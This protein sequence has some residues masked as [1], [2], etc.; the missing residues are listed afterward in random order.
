MGY[1]EDKWKANALESLTNLKR[2]AI[3]YLSKKGKRAANEFV[4]DQLPDVHRS[5][6]VK[7][8]GSHLKRLHQQ[9]AGKKR[10]VRLSR[11]QRQMN[12][13]QA[14]YNNLLKLGPNRQ[15]MRKY[16]SFIRA[17][18]VHEEAKPR[19]KGGLGKLQPKPRKWLVF[20]RF[21]FEQLWRYLDKTSTLYRLAVQSLMHKSRL[22]CP[23]PSRSI[24]ALLGGIL[25]LNA[26]LIT[27][28]PRYDVFSHL[29]TA[30]GL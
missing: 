10:W 3:D 20:H 9:K 22:A 5:G 6:G 13:R 24:P 15:T 16:I 21:H 23:S 2:K 28:L 27:M 11:K 7:P 29:A 26:V 18:H 1:V 4:E 25:L 19:S 30:A 8:P 12:A 17:R 14:M